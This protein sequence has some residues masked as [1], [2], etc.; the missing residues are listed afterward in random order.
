[1]Q[2]FKL[3]SHACLDAL[4][5][6]A[7]GPPSPSREPQQQILGICLGGEWQTRLAWALAKH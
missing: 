6:L 3:S 2:D 7:I 4:G 5:L 1:M